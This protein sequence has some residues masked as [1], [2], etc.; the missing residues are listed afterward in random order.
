MQVGRC[1]RPSHQQRA[2]DRMGGPRRKLLKPAA[3]AAG[4]VTG[5]W[6]ESFVDYLRSECHLAENTVV[7]YHRDLRRFYAGWPAARFAQ[8]TIQDLADYAGWLHRTTSWRRP[9][10]PGTWCR[11]GSS[12]ATCSSKACCATTWPSCWAARS[13][14]SACRT[15]LRRRMVERL[16]EPRSR[17]SRCGGAIGHCWNCSMP[18]AAGRRRSRTCKLQD[19]HLDEGYCLCH[20][21][22]DKSGWC[23]WAAGPSRPCAI[24]GP[25]AAAAGRRMRSPAPSGCCVSRRGHAAAARADLGTVQDAMP[26][27]RASQPTS[28]RTRCGTASPRTAGRRRRP[29]A[30]PGDA[31]P[32]QHRHDANLHARGSRRGS[33]AVHKQFH[34]RG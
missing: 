12:F 25:R 31:R 14:G 1:S 17:A 33:K 19:V 7:A 13:C 11:C 3:V 23:R 16:L 20:G 2:N 9:A 15:C 34:P 4:A 18:R 32:C 22:G 27:R 6:I 24:S 26:P 29:A 28:A 5:R 21:K 8:L 10:S 30:S